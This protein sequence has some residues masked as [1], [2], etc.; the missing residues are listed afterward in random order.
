[1][2][3]GPDLRLEIQPWAF[4]VLVAPEDVAIWL[5]RDRLGQ[6]R[7]LSLYVCGNYSRLLSRIGLRNAEFDVR[8]AFTASQLLSIADDAHH[9][10]VFVEHDPTLYSESEGMAE[11]VSLALRELSRESTV[12]LYSSG[13]DD[14]LRAISA[15]ADR[16]FCIERSAERPK[17]RE[18]GGRA[19]YGRISESQRTLE[20]V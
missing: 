10:F 18:A 9:G 16:M 20:E 13:L 2:D 12:V 1:M 8:R 17:R 14:H 19:R 11:Y 5:L 6:G 3:A 4:N 7:F 15:K